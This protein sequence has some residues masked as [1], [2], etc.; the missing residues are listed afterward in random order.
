M[1]PNF[2]Q[3]RDSAAES[4]PFQHYHHSGICSYDDSDVDE[5]FR[6]LQSVVDQTPKQDILVVQGDCNAKIGEDA[7]ED[8]ETFVDL[9]AIR[10]PMTESLSSWTS[11]STKTLFWKT[12]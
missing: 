10:R 3:T 12:P 8:W 4:K 9:P 2:K 7:Q 6:E 5:F 11:Q 1:S